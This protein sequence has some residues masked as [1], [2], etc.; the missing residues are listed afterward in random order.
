MHVHIPQAGND[1]LALALDPVGPARNLLLLSAADRF[2]LP[3]VDHEEGIFDNPAVGR[4]NQ[5]AADE[6]DL[7]GTRRKG[8]KQ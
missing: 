6:G 5:G 4:V 8:E 1:E 3:A 7:P 2:N